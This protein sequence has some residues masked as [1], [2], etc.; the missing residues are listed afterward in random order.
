LGDVFSFKLENGINCFGQIVAPCP[1]DLGDMLY[2]LYDFASVDQT[3][4]SDIVKKPI[5]AIANLVPG[6][7]EDGSWLIIGNDEIPASSIVLPNYVITNQSL[8]GTVVLRYDGTFVR[9]STTEEQMLAVDNKVSNLRTWTTHT[10]GFESIA[11]YR[12]DDREPNEYFRE[13]LFEGSMWD[14]KFNL[15]GMPLRDFLDKPVLASNGVEFTM[16]KRKL[17]EPPYVV[18]LSIQNRTLY[19]D[20]GRVGEQSKHAVFAINDEITDQSA[21]EHMEKRLQSDGFEHFEH[22]QYSNVTI[23]YVLASE[24]FGTKGDLDRRHRIEELLDKQLR[25]TNNGNCSGGEIGN[26]ELIIFCHVIDPKVAL[27][28]IKKTLKHNGFLENANIS[29][30]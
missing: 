17:G 10:G 20:E 14:A 18:W 3:I 4:V 24:G 9:T 28:M 2:V 13:M 6:D 1:E 16:V 22:D 27:K 30:T 11:K 26:G 12:F 7:I 8:G 25:E 23:R 29:L 5:L 19:I 21:L 15:E